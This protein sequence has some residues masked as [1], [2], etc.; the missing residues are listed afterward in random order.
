MVFMVYVIMLLDVRDPSFLERYGR[1]VL[2]SVAVGGAARRG[3]R[4]RG[5]P[6]PHRDRARTSR[7]LHRG[8]A[9]ASFEVAAVLR[10][11]PRALLAALRAHLGAAARG[12]GRRDRRHQGR[13][14]ARWIGRSCCSR[15]RSRC[16]RLGLVGVMIRRNALVMLMCMELMLNGVIL[17]LVDVR[18]AQRDA[19]RRGARVPG[20]RGRRRRDRHR[21]PD[22]AAAVAAAPHARRRRLLGAEG[23]TMNLL[24][25]I[26]L[27][28][29]AGFVLNGL[30]GPRLGKRLRQRGGLRPAHP[31]V[32]RHGA[33]ASCS[34]RPPTARRWSSPPTPGPWSA[35]SRFDIAFYFDRLSALMTLIVT[36][37]GSLIHI[38]STGYMKDDASYARYFAYLN[39]FL[40]FMLLLVLGRS[41]LVCFVGWE[42]VGLASYLLIGFWFE[43]PAK[44][45]AGK[46]AFITNR[47]GDAGFLL[48]M[49]LLYHALGT[50]D[51][52]ADQRR[53]H[54]AGAARGVGE[55]GRP[56][57]VHRRD[58]Q[59]GAD[60]AARVAAR[61]DGGPDA[62]LGPDP[63]GHDGDRGRLPGRA[64]ERP[65]PAGA[66]GLAG[67]RGGRRSPR[68][69][70]PPPSPSCR[71]TSRRCS[72]TRRSR[73]SA[74]C[75]WRSASAR[76]AWRCS[77]S[78]RTRSSRPACS[79]A[80]AA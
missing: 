71:P 9:G 64:P 58:R 45:Q 68:R 11:V 5:R 49:F 46:K 56:A 52:D 73:S 54:R 7:R 41:L 36:G 66:R 78:T 77:T 72:P 53:L 57:A 2:P 80:P 38:Y 32:P 14:E 28:P 43:D 67:D 65:V 37:V 16:S 61:R 42:G 59:V 60:P 6:R 44:A 23:M 25:L 39:L 18:R 3:A 29:L 22:R 20:V 34:C 76:T 70:S 15:C 55:P 1:A 27:L 63:R 75:S 8:R 30:L 31:R 17:S 35:T 62:G 74:S 13:A 69:S 4:R 51:F 21:D 48:G 40:F 19:V 33:G 47:V 24:T 10:R 26:V 50:L 12:R 79:S